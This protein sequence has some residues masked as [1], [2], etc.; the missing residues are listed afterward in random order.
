MLFGGRRRVE[1]ANYQTSISLKRKT[2]YLDFSH[3][4]L[5]KDHQTRPIWITPDNKIFLETF[6]SKYQQHM[7]L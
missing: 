3:L 6:S 4:T 5:K 2:E 1:D 7:S